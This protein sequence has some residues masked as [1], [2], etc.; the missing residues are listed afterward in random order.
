VHPGK[1]DEYL[2]ALQ[3]AGIGVAVNFRVIHL[4]SYYRR[5]YGY[6]PGNFSIAEAIGNSTI[7]L[8]FYAKLTPA[9]VA[10]IIDAVKRVVVEPLPHIA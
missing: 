5:K 4:M 1:R 9:E 6:E 8:P 3:Q 2:H 10:Y 7:S